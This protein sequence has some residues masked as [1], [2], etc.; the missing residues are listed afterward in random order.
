MLNTDELSGAELDLYVARAEAM[1]DEDAATYYG[2]AW[3]GPDG[4][5]YLQ[6]ASFGPNHRNS[7]FTPS[8]DWS[9]GGPILEREGV[10][11]SP[12]A[13]KPERMWTS[14]LPFKNT[15]PHVPTYGPTA[16]IAGMRAFV[17]ATFGDTVSD[18][19]A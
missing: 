14:W 5:C 6:P 18:P 19:R 16:L 11:I 10:E 12:H 17:R 2:Q 15:D 13:G 9:Q 8:V 1:R 7:R 3:I 4:V